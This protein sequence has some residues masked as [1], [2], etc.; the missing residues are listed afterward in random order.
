MTLNDLECQ[1]SFSQNDLHNMKFKHTKF[2]VS[3]LDSFK[4]VDNKLRK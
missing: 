3:M 4:V 2:E 1:K